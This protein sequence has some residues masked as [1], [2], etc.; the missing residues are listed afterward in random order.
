M[1]T[2]KKLFRNQNQEVLIEITDAGANFYFTDIY[3]REI[4]T[5]KKF[6]KYLGCAGIYEGIRNLNKSISGF[7]KNHD[8]VEVK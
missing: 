1:K 4:N 3:Y 5:N 2:T 7:I 8:L 6:K